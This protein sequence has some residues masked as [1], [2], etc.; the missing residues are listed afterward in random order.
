[1]NMADYK[2]RLYKKSGDLKGE[3]SNL[4]FDECMKLWNYEVENGF[5]SPTIWKKQKNNTY[6]RIEGY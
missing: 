2:I 3:I 1:M 5:P 6:I 4:T